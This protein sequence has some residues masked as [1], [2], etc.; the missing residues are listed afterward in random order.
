MPKP[1]NLPKLDDIFCS[2]FIFTAP[3]VLS[4]DP[5]SV[6][7]DMWSVGVLAFVMLSGYSP[8][9]GDTKQETY[10]NISLVN[11]DFPEEHFG[12]ISPEAQDL[13]TKLCVKEPE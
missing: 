9:A 5:I 4:Y 6:A 12:R 2:H 3:E 13:I 1:S 10:L 11:L 7:A 8:F